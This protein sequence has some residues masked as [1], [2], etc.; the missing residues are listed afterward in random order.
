MSQLIRPIENTLEPVAAILCTGGPDVIRKKA[1]P[2]YK[3]ISGVF[4]C[5]ELKEPKGPKGSCKA[6]T[7]GNGCLFVLEVSD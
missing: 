4:L 1:W 7:E 5:W 3:T 6:F 2:F